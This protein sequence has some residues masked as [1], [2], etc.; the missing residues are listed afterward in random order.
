MEFD[1]ESKNELETSILSAAHAGDVH[2]LETYLSTI[3]DPN[4]YLNHVYNEPHGQKCTVLMIACLNGYEN[5]IFMLLNNFKPD[6]EILNVVRVTDRDQQLET[7]ENATVL[8]AAAALNNFEIVKLLVEHGA[9]VNHRIKT[10]STPLRCACCNDNIQMVRYLVEK[11]ADIHI[12]KMKHFTNLA[13]S[14]FNGHLQ[15]VAYLVDELGCDV[16]E[17]LDDG[18]SPLCAAVY[19]GSLELVQYLLNRGARN[20]VGGYNQMSP[21]MLAAEKRRIDLVNAISCHCSLVEQIEVEELLGSA[22]ICNEL[23]ISDLEQAFEHLS[24]A[25]ELRSIHQLPKTLKEFTHEVFKHRQECQ[26]IDQLK[27]LQSNSNDMYIEALLIRERLLGPTN[28]KYRHSLRYRGALLADNGQYYP[29]LALW[30]YELAFYRQ[31]SIDIDKEDLRQFISIFSSMM[32]ISLPVPIENLHTVMTVVVGE[33]KP[34]ATDFDY[35]LYTLLFL[36]TI[37]SQV[38]YSI[39][40]LLSRRFFCRF[41]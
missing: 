40:K 3:T 30:M 11:G 36:I 41:C 6:L 7:F 1:C 4:S 8:W 31:Y 17:C 25:L 22:F 24:R 9:E 28:A 35:N 33:L 5:M 21:L 26:T 27:E 18:R 20:C 10:N 32:S 12:T 15:M 34:N 2:S 19:H 37:T 23:G 14:V 13:A 39:S 16:N 38:Q 29:G